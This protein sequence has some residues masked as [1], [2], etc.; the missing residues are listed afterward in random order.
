[1]ADEKKWEG[2]QDIPAAEP[3]TDP[4]LIDRVA[5]TAERAG[6]EVIVCINKADRGDAGR[7]ASLCRGGHGHQ[8]VYVRHR[9]TYEHVFPRQ[10]L[11]HPA[12]PLGVQAD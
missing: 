4:F 11:V 12:A 1:M 10:Y 2:T 5:A 9:R 6:C 3:E 7:L 8:R